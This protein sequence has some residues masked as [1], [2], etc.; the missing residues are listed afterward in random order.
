M[1]E[2]KGRQVLKHVCK[3]CSKS[4]P[5]GRSLGGHMRSHITN[6]SAQEAEDNDTLTKATKKIQ[7][8]VINGG[9]G[10]SSSKVVG[11]YDLRENPKKTWRFADSRSKEE[12][13]TPL[14][15]TE[16]KFCKECGKVFHSWKALCGH[17]KCHSG[18]SSIN[19]NSLENQDSVAAGHKVVTDSQS[20]NEETGNNN[21]NPSRRR[22]SKRTRTSFVMTPASTS[23]LSF[24]NNHASSSVSEVEQEQEEGAMSLMMLSRD[25]GHWGGLNS[26]VESSDNNSA[27]FEARS[28]VVPTNLST[29]I[30]TAEG[31]KPVSVATVSFNETELDSSVKSNCKK[32]KFKCT[33]CNKTFDSYQA[34]GGHRSSHK[35]LR[36]GCSALRNDQSS[37]NSIETDL[38]NGYYVIEKQHQELIGSV[39]FENEEEMVKKN[40]VHECPICLKIFPSGQAL[41]GH[42]RSHF[43]AEGSLVLEKPVQ[44]IRD[45]LDLNLPASAEESNSQVMENYPPWWLVQGHNHHHHPKQEPLVGLISN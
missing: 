11:E 34:L 7:S 21:N 27:Y 1:E 43:A 41:G 15:V 29:K 37:E 4:F 23:S 40:K 31:K 6:V 36:G 9:A 3:F 45:F 13:T 2:E 16:D 28:Y 17:M 20:D 35:K 8:S 33:T 32:G 38:N 30:E 18:K 10:E 26:R 22:R 42:K 44:E 25:V 5:S 14:L 39:N 24:A 12:E 19:N